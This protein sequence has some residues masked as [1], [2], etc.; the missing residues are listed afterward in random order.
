MPKKAV[1]ENPKLEIE[2]PFVSR[3]QG[4][5]DRGS[6]LPRTERVI[7]EANVRHRILSLGAAYTSQ[8]FGGKP[9][10]SAR[11]ER[12]RIGLAPFK[13]DWA[14]RIHAFD[15]LEFPGLGVPITPMITPP[16][17]YYTCTSALIKAP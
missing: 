7:V 4:R 9:S 5:G 2:V 15:L 13:G 16:S 3:S 12:G 6:A 17:A 11:P 1:F 14:R 8:P 10:Q